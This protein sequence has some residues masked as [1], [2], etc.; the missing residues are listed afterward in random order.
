MFT[1]SEIDSAAHSPQF[2]QDRTAANQAV[3]EL[4]AGQRPTPDGAAAGRIAGFIEAVLVSSRDWTPSDRRRNCTIA[5]EL[6]E[7]LA[8]LH[9]DEE[10]VRRFRLKTALLYELAELPA[11]STV[12]RRGDTSGLVSDFFN[13]KGFFETLGQNGAF[14]KFSENPPLG[15]APNSLHSAVSEDLLSL[16][17]FE[18]GK[19]DLKITTFP[20]LQRAASIFSLPLTRTELEALENA[21]A[22]RA[23]YCVRSNVSREL[24]ESASN[25]RFPSEFWRPQV[26]AIQSGLLDTGF[27]SWGFAAPTGSGKTFLTRL[28]I[29]DTLAKDPDAKILY[30]VPSRAL[31]HE[32]SENLK[33][34]LKEFGQEVV[35]VSAVIAAL[36]EDDTERYHDAS[37][38]VL[39][40]EKADLLLRIGAEQIAKSSLVIVDEAHHLE[41]GTRG[42]LLELYLWRIRYLMKSSAR[43]VLLSAVAPNIGD[44]AKWLGNSPGHIA[45]DYRPTRMRAGVYRISGS[46]SAIEYSD[47]VKI[48]VLSAGIAKTQRRQ[49]VQLVDAIASTGPILVVAKGKKE[50]ENIAAEMDKW[51]LAR[52][53]RKDLSESEMNSDV[54]KRLDSRLEREMYSTV[55]LRE[56]IKHRIAYHHAGLPPR[57]RV[58]VEDAIRK[59]L[60]DYVFA[61][62]TLAEGVNFPF[63]AVIVQSL[64]LR[65]PPEKGRPS[66]YHTITPRTFWNIAGRAGRPGF[67]REGQ[68]ILFEPSLGTDKVDLVLSNYLDTSLGGVAPVKSAL[69][70]C[71]K[72]INAGIETGDITRSDL[73]QIILS[74]KIPKRIRGAIN[75]I[76]VSYIH[77]AATMRL[78]GVE[79]ILEGTFALSH[80]SSDESILAHQLFRSQAALVDDFFSKPDAPKPALVAELG[81]SIDTLEQLR[82]YVA[83][84]SNWQI[85]SF[86][87]LFHGGSVNL[88]QSKFVIGPV[89]KRMS[90]LEGPALGGL[91]SDVIIQWLSGIS[92]TKITRKED[93]WWKRL[94]DLISVIYSRIQFLLPWGLYAM[95]RIVD[96][97]AKRRSI[98]YNNEI[99]KLAYLADAGVPSFDALTLV[100]LDIERVDAARLASVFRKSGGYSTGVD[101]VGW[102]LSLPVERAIAIVKG[103]DQRRIDH[104]FVKTLSAL[105][106]QQA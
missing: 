81:L 62:T 69:A 76:R 44:I 65:E 82:Q 30:I 26:E 85:E 5:G 4:R 93:D 102:V 74:E 23:K 90:E 31:V 2:L 34:L 53:K 79:E 64:V 104:D 13:R 72:D 14:E 63:S 28:L 106:S 43:I 22:V 8:E 95:D 103:I 71:L 9:T 59:G 48:S 33:K 25:A 37:V 45:I 27:D 57:V 55:P 24:F 100:N 77:A 49:L 61:T 18:Q 47:G 15:E 91:F 3:M 1:A 60:V 83:G 12:L 51:L 50:C 94:E 73:N 46:T 52:G 17:N 88:N 6:S 68:V 67:D 35:A 84:L 29:L 78:T 36:H 87:G 56:F 92:L 105:R 21:V 40:P 10:F 86:S 66:K 99:G 7:Y 58:A 75:L 70:S 54:I 16:A 80:L 89:A 97:E 19:S 41:A 38:F 11:L 101:I 32:V 96:E 42:F 98:P 20:L 39:T